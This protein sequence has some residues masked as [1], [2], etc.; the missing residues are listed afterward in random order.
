M[1]TALTI[2]PG[3]W[4]PLGATR[5]MIAQYEVSPQESGAREGSIQ[6]A[7]GKMQTD[8]PMNDA[9]PGH[10]QERPLQQ[11]SLQ[12]L[13]QQ[14]TRLERHILELPQEGYGALRDSLEESL[15]A[16]RAEVV[17]RK[18]EGQA[19][20]QAIARHKQ[21]A[22]A[23]QVAEQNLA[24]AR[25]TLRIATEAYDQTCAAEDAAA[26]EVQKQRSAISD[27]DPP[28]PSPALLPT[29]TMVGLYQ[30]LQQAGI[31][32]PHLREVAALL[33]TQIP[34]RP[35]P[36]VA[37]QTQVGSPAAPA[38]L[39][40]EGQALQHPANLASQLLASGPAAPPGAGHTSRNGR[41]PIPK[42]RLPQRTGEADFASTCRDT[43]PTQRSTSRTPDRGTAG[44]AGSPHPRT[45]ALSPTLPMGHQQAVPSSLEGV[46]PAS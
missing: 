22:K 33:G 46:A 20:D 39:D 43:S 8:V 41:S 1:A 3:Q 13:R 25:E 6:D 37:P 32:E 42:R 15:A 17:A 36:P 30:I 26:Q 21:A 38:N 19:L 2:V 44:P 9:A 11:L 23:K 12:H 34:P 31:S 14:I 28:A 24:K 18:P 16:T 7:P 35:P 5:A 45:G 10:V 27:F 40:N 29:P 4:P